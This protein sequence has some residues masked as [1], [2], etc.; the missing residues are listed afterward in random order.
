MLATLAVALKHWARFSRQR[1]A[2]GLAYL[3]GRWPMD[4]LRSPEGGRWLARSPGGLH[5]YA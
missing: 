1:V 4:S 3:A 5:N 2:D